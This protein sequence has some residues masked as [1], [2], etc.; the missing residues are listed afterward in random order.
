ML[1]SDS[2]VLP[3]PAGGR[4]REVSIHE[5][6]G[7]GMEHGSA[8]RRS[9]AS[10]RNG[11]RARFAT[12]S[13]Q[14]ATACHDR[15]PERRSED[16]HA[17]VR[18]ARKDLELA[19]IRVAVAGALGRMGRVA[20]QR[21]AD[22]PPA[23]HTP[24]V[25]RVRAVPEERSLR[26]FR[27]SCWTAERPTCCSTSRRS[28]SARDISMRAIVHGVRPV[29][30]RNGLVITRSATRSRRVAA[31]AGSRR[32]DRAELLDR[33]DPDDAFCRSKRRSFFPTVEIVELHHD[34]KQ[35]E[36]SGTARAH[37][38]DASRRPADPRRCADSQ[39]ASARSAR[40]SRSA[41]RDRR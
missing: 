33:S 26:R 40:A 39:R 25:S 4:W 27:A 38:R 14:A 12:S 32:D 34:E 37:R 31:R 20:G 35:D 18:A 22:L 9:R 11:V 29:I 6:A 7:A 21:Y 24:V 10:S 13:A 16:A 28:R 23:F 36:P 1:E 41:L 3:R 2:V 5:S 30:G 15:L 8:R 17:E 19:M